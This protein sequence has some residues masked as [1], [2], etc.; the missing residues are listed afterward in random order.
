MKRLGKKIAA[1]FL[2]AVAVFGTALINGL[3]AIDTDIGSMFDTKVFAA[4]YTSGVISYLVNEDGEVII[5]GSHKDSGRL[6][7]PAEINGKPVVRIGSDAFEYSDISCIVIP[8]SVKTIG[9]EAFNECYLLESVELGNGI[10]EIEE[11]AFVNCTKLKEIKF[12]DSVKTIGEGAFAYCEKLE[13]VDLGNGIEEIGLSAFEGCAALKEIKIPDSMDNIGMFA[14]SYCD[15]LVS[16]DLGNGVEK[17]GNSAFMGCI[18][19]RHIK[20]PDSVKI[21]DKNAFYG[22]DSLEKADLGNGVEELGEYAF[23]HCVALREIKIPDSMKTVGNCAFRKCTSLEKADLGNG[24]EKIE[25][26][27]FYKCSA[28]TSVEIPSSVKEI[29]YSVFEGSSAIE[30]ITVNPENRHLVLSDGVIYSRDMKT[31]VS[32][33]DTAITSFEVPES[34][35]KIGYEAFCGCDELKAVHFGN[36]VEEIDDFAFIGRDIREIS[37][38]DTVKRIGYSAFAMCTFLER[39]DIGNGIEVIDCYAFTKCPALTQIELPES[40]KQIN[41]GAFGE[42]SQPTTVKILYR[43]GRLQWIMIKKDIR[44]FF[45]NEIIFNYSRPSGADSSPI[46]DGAVRIRNNPSVRTVKYGESLRLTAEYNNANAEK[47]L[48]YVDGE[49]R[50]EGFSFTVSPEKSGCE[51]KAVLADKDGNPVNDAKGNEA[52]DSQRI[53]VKAGVIN[54]LVSFFKNLFKRDRII[55]Q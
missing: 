5:V 14:F 41:Y 15:S 54:K 16:A 12:P 24:V 38:P 3:S 7:I 55:V 32:I 44:D 8:D 11:R 34:V 49:F 29:G 31:L 13:S 9:S 37:L 21:I 53:E 33:I 48:W 4:P 40:V 10:K 39:A 30:N 35:T 28:L 43:G 52:C 18:S 23:A 27:A 26:F 19:L 6:E 42:L 22:C 2:A 17:I 20:I 1:V 25:A 36:N 51:V 50:G 47:V 45:K 46:K